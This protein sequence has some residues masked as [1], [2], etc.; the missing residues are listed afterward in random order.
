MPNSLVEEPIPDQVDRARAPCPF[1][2]QSAPAGGWLSRIAVSLAKSRQRRALAGLA[3]LNHR[4]ED[5]GVSKEEPLPEAAR[6]FWR[7]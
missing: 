7:R 2:D 4:L 6:P 5:I 1:A 3:K